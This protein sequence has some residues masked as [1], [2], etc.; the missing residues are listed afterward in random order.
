MSK[1]VIFPAVGVFA[2]LAVA[3]F[4]WLVISD[5]P[6]VP[7]SQEPPLSV[8]KVTDPL[9]NHVPGKPAAA[10][11][12]SAA[13]KD[14]ATDADFLANYADENPA[15]ATMDRGE[16]LKISGTIAKISV[17][18]FNQLPQV[19]LGSGDGLKTH[20]L[21]CEFSD[22]RAVDSLKVGEEVVL[23]GFGDPVTFKQIRFS[24]C[25]LVKK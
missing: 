12:Y 22:K 20:K 8:S 24:K 18:S 7:A 14:S 13:I 15:R 3:Y 10:D 16:W 1:N 21:I 23:M 4:F 2:A 6:R 17:N 5:S 9:P 25:H 11:N 19:H